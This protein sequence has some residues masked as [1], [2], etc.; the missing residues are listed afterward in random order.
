MVPAG[1]KA[2]RFSSVNHT[3]KT[4]H[5]HHHYLIKVTFPIKFALSSKRHWHLS[6]LRKNFSVAPIRHE[7]ERVYKSIRVWTLV[8][9]L[10]FVHITK[11]YFYLLPIGQIINIFYIIQQKWILEAGWQLTVVH[12]S[13]LGRHSYNFYFWHK[14]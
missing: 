7:R 4:I 14:F 5:H 6:P 13:V 8:D 10:Y 11:N 3:T 9:I 1:N 12:I 2:K